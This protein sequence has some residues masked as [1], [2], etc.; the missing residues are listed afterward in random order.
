MSK[1]KKTNVKR[2]GAKPIATTPFV[3]VQ[4]KREDEAELLISCGDMG[5]EIGEIRAKPAPCFGLLWDVPNKTDSRG[6]EDDRGNLKKLYHTDI[7]FHNDSPFSLLLRV[8]RPYGYSTS[9]RSVAMWETALGSDFEK[10]VSPQSSVVCHVSHQR[11]LADYN[12]GPL[13]QTVGNEDHIHLVTFAARRNAVTDAGVLIAEVSNVVAFRVHIKTIYEST[14]SKNSTAV[15][16]VVRSFSD[17]GVIGRVDPAPPLPVPMGLLYNNTARI[18]WAF[19]NTGQNKGDGRYQPARLGFVTADYGIDRSIYTKNVGGLSKGQRYVLS[20]GL[21][22]VHPGKIKVEYSTS[23]PELP[24]VIK[25]IAEGKPPDA[26]KNFPVVPAHIIAYVE[27][28]S[29]VKGY[30][31]PLDEGWYIFHTYPDHND[32]VYEPE[33]LA[34]YFEPKAGVNDETGKITAENA[35]ILTQSVSFI[36]DGG[37]N[38]FFADYEVKSFKKRNFKRRVETPAGDLHGEWLKTT[39]WTDTTLNGISIILR[40][41]KTAISVAG[42]LGLASVPVPPT[43]VLTHFG[44]KKEPSLSESFE[45]LAFT[46]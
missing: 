17:D 2:I 26:G 33:C 34:W 18:Q 4:Y 45:N 10:D 29:T 37:Q 21:P 13:H 32:H 30:G 25:F 35:G 23:T 19:V 42:V 1:I 14:G 20:K 41:M 38:A 39:T 46:A 11:D 40:V 16:Y 8:C 12:I 22:C 6:F 5:L 43:K 28:S 36:P 27:K 9:P 15:Q 3:G 24:P 44:R 7:E 31:T